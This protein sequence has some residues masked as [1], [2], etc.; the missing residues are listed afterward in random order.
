MIC[1]VTSRSAEK[2]ATRVRTKA[3]KNGN[4]EKRP[5]FLVNDKIIINYM[6]DS[7]SIKLLGSSYIN[8]NRQILAS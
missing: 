8:I 3:A 4:D 5:F 2:L 7:I 1:L 6:S